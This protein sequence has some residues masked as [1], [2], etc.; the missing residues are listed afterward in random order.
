MNELN[1]DVLNL[2]MLEGEMTLLTEEEQPNARVP[3]PKKPTKKKT[4]YDCEVALMYMDKNLT[5]LP[6]IEYY[7]QLKPKIAEFKKTTY[8][9]IS[10]ED[11]V[12]IK[13]LDDFSLTII[14]KSI[15]QNVNDMKEILLE[16][17][18]SQDSK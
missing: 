4:Q 3:E 11:K 16:K 17:A 6:S 2:E 1:I 18:G 14:N 13:L 5:S 10:A 15:T 7:K 8:K 12:I 9:S